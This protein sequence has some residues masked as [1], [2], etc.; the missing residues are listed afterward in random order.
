[1]HGLTPGGHVRELSLHEHRSL[2]AGLLLL[3]GL[4]GLEEVEHFCA[5]RKLHRQ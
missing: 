4:G 5:D 1:M 3:G 2:A